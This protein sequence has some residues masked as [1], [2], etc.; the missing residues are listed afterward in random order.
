[1]HVARSRPHGKQRPATPNFAANV[2]SRFLHPSLHCHLNWRIHVHRPG[3]GGNVGVES[4]VAR[5][6]YMHIARPG[7]DFPRATLRALGR[8]VATA[9]LSVEATLNATNGVIF[10]DPVCRSTLPDP[11]SSISMSPLPVPPFTAPA[12]SWART[13]P[14]SSLQ[15]NLSAVR[16]ASFRSPDPVC[17]SPHCRACPR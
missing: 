8:D 9:R 16:W 3:T 4:R 14:D 15:V 6:T 1:M 7:V 11:V 10:P 13:S 2:L 17:T 12:I 5:Q